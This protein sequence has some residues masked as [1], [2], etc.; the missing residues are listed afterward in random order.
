MTAGITYAQQDQLKKLPIPELE[1]TLKKYI[2]SLKPLQ[3]CPILQHMAFSLASY[4]YVRLTEDAIMVATPICN[5]KDTNYIFRVLVNIKTPKK[6]S[7]TSWRRQ[8]HTFKKNS[9]DTL[10]PDHHTLNS[11]GTILTSIMTLQSS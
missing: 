2:D 6:R 9:K 11:S 8:V 5:W 1:D 7:K 4:Y 10:P 3:V